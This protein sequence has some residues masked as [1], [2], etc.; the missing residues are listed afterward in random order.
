MVRWILD[1]IAR[2]G[3]ERVPN[4]SNYNKSHAGLPFGHCIWKPTAKEQE[5]IDE[6]LDYSLGLFCFQS[7][8]DLD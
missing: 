8:Q 4:Y 7:F 5:F 6:G 2:L 3:F 1:R